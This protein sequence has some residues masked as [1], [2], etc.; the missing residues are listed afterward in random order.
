MWSYLFK[1][2]LTVVPTVFLVLVI[3]FTLI[4]IIPGDPAE[5]MLYDLDDH[6]AVARLRSEMGLDKPIPV[7]FA[8][9]LG[10]LGRGD[11]GTSIRTNEQV[12]PAIL[13]RFQ[14]TAT[15][16]V[17]AVTLAV[18]I[19][20]PAGMVA[21][22]RQNTATDFAIVLLA[23]VKLSL[24][25]FWV[26]LML[27]LYFGV[28]LH[29]LPTVGYVALSE[30]F[31][32]GVIYLIM[33]VVSLALTEIAVLIRMM[34]SG[35]LEVLRLEYVTHARA[36]G[37]SE[38]AVLA[39]HVFKNAFAPALTMLGLIMASLLGGAAVTETVFSL[40]G[41]GKLVVDSIY[42]RDYPMLQ[43]ALLLIAMVYVA[44][45]LVVDL[46]YGFLDPRVR[47]T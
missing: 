34:R 7:Q 13:E 1:R 22:W 30:D 10:Q 41:L 44:V 16:V 39:R 33:P 12:L 27:L 40:P 9:W 31:G 38:A 17:C 3:V 32:L 14:V 47:L 11:L 28:Y 18:F 35:T 4:R 15:L 5:L 25:S 23:I 37:L 42:A 45:N 26:G 29:W 19:A 6:A 24:P 8:Y 2:M 21:A 36:K 43:G 20:I 46:L